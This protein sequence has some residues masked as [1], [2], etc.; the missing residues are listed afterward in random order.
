MAICA[1][2][3]AGG[4]TC[5][6]QVVDSPTVNLTL[7]GSGTS[8]D[9]WIL[10]GEASASGEDVEIFSRDESALTVGTG[11]IVLSLP[12][13]YTILGISAAVFTAP[14][15][16][17][18]ILDVNL[19]GTTIFT[20]QAN[21]PRIVAGTTNTVGETVPD[22]TAIPAYGHVTVDRDQVGSIIAGGP[23]TLFVRYQRV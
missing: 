20:T 15:G 22:V 21:R 7:V 10:L 1:G 13:A 19:N 3:S 18:I 23:L 16:A 14:T 4:C 12:F 9:P 5:A 6:L 17:D 8:G 2:C 11:T